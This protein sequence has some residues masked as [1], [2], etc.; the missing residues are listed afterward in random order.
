M[1]YTACLGLGFRRLVQIDVMLYGALVLL[2]FVSL[3]VLRI[4]EPQLVRPFRIPG[5]V[6]VAVLLGAMP[7]SL[8]GLSLWY[9]RNES[10]MWGFSAVTIGGFVIALGPLLFLLSRW[11]GQP[12]GPLSP[13]P[14]TS[15]TPPASRSPVETSVALSI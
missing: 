1:L 10:G 13:L 15:P 8:L 3:V 11:L 2:E 9:G 12:R 6:V 7:V 14:V 4:R 5:G